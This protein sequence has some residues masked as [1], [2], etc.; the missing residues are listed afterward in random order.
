MHIATVAYFYNFCEGVLQNELYFR[1]ISFKI[2]VVNKVRKRRKLKMQYLFPLLH[3]YSHFLSSVSTY[4]LKGKLKL[5]LQRL[6]GVI[7][8]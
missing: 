2:V 7:M 8:V 1:L 4:H 5:T 6:L 3:F